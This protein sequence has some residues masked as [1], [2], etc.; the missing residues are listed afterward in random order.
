VGAPLDEA[1]SIGVCQRDD[2]AGW[3]QGVLRILRGAQSVPTK[4]EEA[5]KEGRRG[6]EASTNPA[7]VEGD[8][9]SWTPFD[10]PQ[11]DLTVDLM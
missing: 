6:D 9:D 8:G 4:L 5:G 10:V 11:S 2:C 3:W 1:A 7:T